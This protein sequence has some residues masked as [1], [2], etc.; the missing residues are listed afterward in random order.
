MCIPGF[1]AQAALYG[2]LHYYAT[3]SGSVPAW[4]QPLLAAMPKGGF[5]P[6]DCEVTCGPY[7]PDCMRTCSVDCHPGFPGNSHTFKE[8]RCSATEG[9]C[10][11]E[12]LDFQHDPNCGACGKKCS[13]SSSTC[14]RG[15]C[16]NL[17]QSTRNCGECGRDCR[18]GS[19]EAG[20]CVCPSGSNTCGGICCPPGQDCSHGCCVTNADSVV[21][22]SDKNVLLFN[23]CKNIEDLTVSLRVTEHL[24]ATEGFSLQ[25]NAYSP[26]GSSTD[27]LQYIFQITGNEIAGV[28]QYWDTSAACCHPHSDVCDCVGPVVNTRSSIRS[29][30]SN[31]IPAGFELKVF[32]NTDDN[33]R[34]TSATF[35]VIDDHG[36]TDSQTIDIDS[37]D[38]H[39]IRAFEVNAVGLGN[40]SNAHF[41]S[42]A[43]TITYEVLTGELCVEGGLPER[44]T[45]MTGGTAETSNA[46]YGPMGPQCC[47]SRLSQSLST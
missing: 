20:V 47:D 33:E 10:R 31:A 6:P 40:S 44:C 18:P 4:P 9:C 45:N 37:G 1:T 35:T 41:S 7:G 3:L 2:S 15:E 24:V 38:L 8:S 25:L 32:L 14:C 12:C 17:R 30:S 23:G 11:G 34:V 5:N 26:P 27:W 39:R 21:L 22:G 42:G 29:L 43:G 28:V 36:H 46:K 19:C 13:G 16:V